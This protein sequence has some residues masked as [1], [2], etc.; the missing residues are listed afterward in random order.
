VIP[1]EGSDATADRSKLE[2]WVPPFFSFAQGFLAYRQCRF[3]ESAAIMKGDAATVL[4]PAPGL[5]LA[6]AQCQLGQ[7]TRSPK[8]IGESAQNFRL[9]AGKSG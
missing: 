8:H 1:A 6:M 4:G 9:A 2:S 5:L 3:V 7:K